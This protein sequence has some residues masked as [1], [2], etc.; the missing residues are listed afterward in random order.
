MSDD[1]KVMLTEI[2]HLQATPLHQAQ[3]PAITP[4]IPQPADSTKL[5]IEAYGDCI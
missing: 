4:E 3:T 5:W 2:V 1:T